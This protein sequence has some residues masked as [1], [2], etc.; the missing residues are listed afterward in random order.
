MGKKAEIHRPLSHSKGTVNRGGETLRSAWSGARVDLS[1]WD[2]AVDVLSDFRMAHG[3]PLQMVASSLRYHVSKRC[4]AGD[5]GQRLKRLPTIIDKL[6]RH[7]SMALARMQDI[8]GCRAVVADE[9][10]L[11]LVLRQLRKSNAWTIVNEKD[12][13]ATPKPDGYRAFH[14]VVEKEGRAIEIQLR[15][16]GNHDWAELVESVDRRHGLG[17]KVGRASTDVQEYFRLGADMIAAREAG[18]IPDAAAV[19]RF[20]DLHESV[21]HTLI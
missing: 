1:A 7:P 17:L 5:V 18:A 20:R 3:Y 15:T 12:Y 6:S 13:L 19:D 16:Q 11:R 10:D 21:G 14:L 4:V 2:E 9:S 8:G